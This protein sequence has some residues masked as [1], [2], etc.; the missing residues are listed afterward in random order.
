MTKNAMKS[1]N[2][3]DIV[4]AWSEQDCQALGIER[5]DAI[6]AWKVLNS[7]AAQKVSDADLLSMGYEKSSSYMNVIIHPNYLRA[8]RVMMTQYTNA[9]CLPEAIRTNLSIAQD[10]SA[11]EAARVRAAGKLIDYAEQS[12]ERFR[13]EFNKGADEL[14]P[15]DLARVI[16]YLEGM[17]AAGLQVGS[18]DTSS[19]DEKRTIDVHSL[20][21]SPVAND[22]LSDLM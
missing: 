13:K 4:F 21:Q 16:K 5:R 17:R 12:L 19:I 7:G 9:V 11:P 1:T 22:Y 6:L 15:D 14:A 10:T 8:M 18:I 2:E 3:Q 20:V